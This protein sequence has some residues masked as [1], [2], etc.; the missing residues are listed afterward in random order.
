MRITEFGA[1]DFH[2]RWCTNFVL[3]VITDGK[4]H[5]SGYVADV[6]LVSTPTLVESLQ[7]VV[8][9]ISISL[10]V[11]SWGEGY[12]GKLGHNNR[13]NYNRLKLV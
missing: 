8:W 7:Q 6:R 2:L 1:A 5:A 9:L 3:Y 4:L 13:L 10:A 11:Y 12:D